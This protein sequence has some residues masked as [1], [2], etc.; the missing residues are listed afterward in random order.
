VPSRQYGPPP[1][2]EVPQQLPPRVDIPDESSEE[3]SDEDSKDGQRPVI[4]IANAVANGNGNRNLL[5]ATQQGQF[6]QYYILLPDSSLQKVRYATGQTDDDR[7]LN[8]FSAQL[9]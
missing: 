5:A 2:T 1:P 3:D 8:G 7:T 4:A 6:G 9:K